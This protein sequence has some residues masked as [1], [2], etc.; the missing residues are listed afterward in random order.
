MPVGKTRRLDGTLVNTPAASYGPFQA[1][2]LF[3]LEPQFKWILT[4]TPLVNGIEDLCRVL[5][6]LQQDS[7]WEDNLPPDTLDQAAME[8][9][10]D[11]WQPNEMNPILGTE[12]DAKFTKIANPYQ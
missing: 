3:C 1:A 5:T 8:P 6:F 4:A 10:A 7:W 2:A 12:P 11:D 9:Q